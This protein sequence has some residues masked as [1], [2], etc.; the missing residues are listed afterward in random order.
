MSQ[1]PLGLG[2]LDWSNWAK[3]LIAGFIGSAAGTGNTAIGLMMA[4]S[5]HFNPQTGAF[6]RTLAFTALVS[7]V[8][9]MLAYLAKAP[10]PPEKVVERSTTITEVAGK[11][12]V[13]ASTVKETTKEPVGVPTTDVKG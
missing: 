2:N 6:W 8:T 10:V 5:N 7:G 4:D 3:G 13:V 11:P 9:T 1:L 12:A